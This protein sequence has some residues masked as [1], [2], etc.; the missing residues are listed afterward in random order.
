MAAG[1]YEGTRS[2]AWWA[3]VYIMVAVLAPTLFVLC[4]F[5]R[6]RVTGLDI[7]LR[8]QRAVPMIFT[9]IAMAVAGGLL[10][11]GGAPKSLIVLAV[12]NQALSVVLLLVTLWWKISVHSAVAG[13]VGLGAWYL[14]RTP[15]PL[16]LG[17]PTVWWARWRLRRPS[18]ISS[19]IGKPSAIPST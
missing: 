7:Q 1:A 18:I 17:V 10:W 6:G 5:R 11:I 4:L 8:E 9:L 2:A 16:V 14:L 19:S 13:A 3:A 15:L 12:V